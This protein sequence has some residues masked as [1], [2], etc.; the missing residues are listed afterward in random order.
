MKKYKPLTKDKPTLLELILA[1]IGFL[2]IIFGIFIIIY[3][4]L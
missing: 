3:S 1:G 2:S 4:L